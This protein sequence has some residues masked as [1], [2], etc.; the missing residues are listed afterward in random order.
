MEVE[1]AEVSTGRLDLQ[2]E[3]Q[4]GDGLGVGEME[5]VS[6]RGEG[7]GPFGG[8]GEVIHCAE[9]DD[10]L[11]VDEELC[12]FVGYEHEAVIA[13]GLDPEVGVVVD[14]EPFGGSADA[15]RA[16]VEDLQGD[17]EGGGVD[18]ADR[19][20]RIEVGHAGWEDGAPVRVRHQL[21]DIA[22]EGVGAGHDGAEL[23]N[24]ILLRARGGG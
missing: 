18:L 6:S 15:K 20:H 5:G 9:V 4:V 17:V 12:A 3:L 2:D 14:A 24:G 22:A 16:R 23:A 1:R 19:V 10:E 7:D 21:V 11:V 8:L 13:G